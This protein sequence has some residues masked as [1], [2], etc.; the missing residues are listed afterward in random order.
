MIYKEQLTK[1]MEL[2]AQHSQTVFLGQALQFGGTFQHQTMAE[3]EPERIIEMPV[4]EEMQLGLSLGL[5]LEG[6]IPVTIYPRLSFFLLAMNQL[7]NHVDKYRLITDGEWSP[8]MIIRVG[9]GG[10]RFVDP[11]WQHIGDWSRQISGMLSTV[12]TVVLNKASEIVPAYKYA[13]ERT[14]GRSTLL[15][16]YADYYNLSDDELTEKPR[17]A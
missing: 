14:D 10:R 1:A 17:R 13:L 6:Y 2:L 7:V 16:E 11:G 3:I 8:H 15:F 5:T 9:I 4:C 12:E